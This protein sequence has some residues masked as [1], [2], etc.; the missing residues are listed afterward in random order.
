MDITYYIYLGVLTMASLTAIV[1]LKKAISFPVRIISLLVLYTG[2]VEWGVFYKTEFMSEKE[3]A[4]IYNCFMLMQYVAFAHYFQ[5]IIQL[6]WARKV[7]QV[8]LYLFP[9][10]W[11][12]LVFFVFKFSEWNSYVY[13]IGGVF[14]IFFAI[15]YCYELLSAEE[16]LMLRNCSEFWV[17]IGLI[18]FYVCSVPY[19]GMYRFLTEYHVN[20]ATLLWVPLQ[21]SNIVMYSLF[22]YAFICQLTITKRS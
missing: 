8:F 17:A 19:M 16:P 11:Y 6:R 14:T 10:L 5:Q 7:I 21:I 1:S 9:V 13:M 20:L 15:V 4:Q 2:V 22:T 3:S 12:L 18:F